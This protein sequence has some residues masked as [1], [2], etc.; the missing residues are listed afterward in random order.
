MT[1]TSTSRRRVIGSAAGTGLLGLV[2]P[3]SCAG[4]GAPDVAVCPR[5][6]QV[7]AV[8]PRRVP[9]PA[10][11]DCPA[12]WAGPDY[13]DEVSRLIV[14][15]KDRGRH[16]VTSVL[17]GVLAAGLTTALRTLPAEALAGPVC[18]VPVPSSRPATRRRGGQPVHEVLVAA[19]RRVRRSGAVPQHRLRIVPALR[20]T[21]VVADQAG[22]GAQARRRNLDGAFVVRH[23]AMRSVEGRAVVLV[24]D[25]LTTGSTLAEAARA[26]L[27]AGGSIT[28]VCALCVTPR[29]GGLSPGPREG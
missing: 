9:V 13:A 27:A 21:R 22:L 24:D 11:P 16:D 29:N 19:A 6:R 20:L 12:A 2:W 7:L 10:W 23:S 28:A 17:A 3:V 1:I 15:W 5:C 25:V 4:C 14:H 26:V 8:P 18:L